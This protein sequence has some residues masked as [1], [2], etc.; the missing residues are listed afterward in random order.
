MQIRGKLKTKFGNDRKCFQDYGILQSIDYID[1]QYYQQDVG[2]N[3]PKFSDINEPVS[4]L[5]IE[6]TY[7]LYDGYHRAFQNI[8]KEKLS[9][10]GKII[11]LSK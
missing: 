1:I 4:I 10:Q 7:I 2:I 3:G 11:Q 6:K 9:I 5:Q 8:L